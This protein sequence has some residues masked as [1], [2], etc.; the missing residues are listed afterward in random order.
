[1][2]IL[3]DD[4]LLEVFRCC[5]ADDD[6]FL[7]SWT[8]KPLV[9]VCKRWRQIIL[10]SPRY[11]HLVLLCNRRT[12]VRESL[13]IW[14]RLPI[15]I[16]FSP[17]DMSDQ[18][19]VIF[20]LQ[21]R[22]HIVDVNFS[23]ISRSWLQKISAFMQAPL[24]ALTKLAL[25]AKSSLILPE[26]FLGGSAPR[27]RSCMLN[28]IAFPALPT[29]LTSTRQLVRLFL[30]DIPNTGYIP[31]EVMA[32]CLATLPN[33]EWFR[34]RF[35]SPLGSIAPPD[36]SSP[37]PLE[38]TNLPVLAIFHFEGHSE[39]LEQVLARIDAPS[40]HHLTVFFSFGFFVSMSQLYR[41]INNIEGLKKCQQAT[42]E[43]SRWSVTLTDGTQNHLKLGSSWGRLGSRISSMA[44]LL[45]HLLSRVELLVIHTHSVV[46]TQRDMEI[47]QWLALLRPFAAV[48]RLI[49]SSELVPIF[50][51]VL[52]D[53]TGEKDIEVLPGLRDLTFAGQDRYTPVQ[54]AVMIKPFL[55]ARQLLGRPVALEY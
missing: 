16:S 38:R 55:A 54:E 25:S 7:H 2:D 11:L 53:L 22:D 6:A 24:P 5:R 45:D 26:T 33:L 44:Q 51:H 32:P 37:L 15:V 12:P 14:P 1:M 31:P 29:L 30:H 41:F 39:Y 13:D 23:G 50:A 40:L 27:L 17:T 18:E 9:H 47:T 4:A 21:H 34:L 10:A 36:L 8:W 42:V 43:L 48:G 28:G 19:S 46:Q 3:P 20:A 35:R 52:R 49:I